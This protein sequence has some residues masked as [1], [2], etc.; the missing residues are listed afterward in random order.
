MPFAIFAAGREGDKIADRQVGTDRHGQ[1]VILGRVRPIG[2]FL[3]GEGAE[4]EMLLALEQRIVGQVGIAEIIGQ[5]R[6]QR[7]AEQQLV[8]ARIGLRAF[9]IGH[10]RTDRALAQPLFDTGRRRP[11]LVD[12][13]AVADLLFDAGVAVRRGAIGRSGLER[14]SLHRMPMRSRNSSSSNRA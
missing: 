10:I 7:G 8:A 13:L 12:L 2:I 14:P 6:S 1:F 5:G 3:K 4:L 11:D 9:A